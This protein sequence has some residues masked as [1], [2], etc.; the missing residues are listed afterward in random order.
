MNSL[1]WS[2]PASSHIYHITSYLL[3][4]IQTIPLVSRGVSHHAHSRKVA[5]QIDSVVSKFQP[6][7]QFY[8]LGFFVLCATTPAYELD[9]H[10]STY[11]V[12]SAKLI[13]STYFVH[14]KIMSSSPTRSSAL[15]GN[16]LVI[17]KTRILLLIS[18]IAT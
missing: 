11:F 12:L 7:S 4:E 5:D 2:Y 17:N 18:L 15:G 13:L 3:S 14:G 9:L 10:T 1:G 6:Q 8:P 16:A